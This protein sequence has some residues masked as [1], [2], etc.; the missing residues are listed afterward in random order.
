MDDKDKA[1]G[2]DTFVPYDHIMSRTNLLKSL[3][4]LLGREEATS[5]IKV[6]EAKAELEE[7]IEGEDAAIGGGVESITMIGAALPDVNPAV[8]KRKPGVYMVMGDTAEIIAKRYKISREAQDEYSLLS[9]QRTARAQEEGLFAD[10][11]APMD[12]TYGVIDKETKKIAEKVQTTADK[13]ECNRPNTTLEAL[14][15]RR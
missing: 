12:V 11:I 10:E 15:G 6:R 5:T 14:L 13:D 7:I 9:Q 1:N 4:G 2:T 8:M 3:G